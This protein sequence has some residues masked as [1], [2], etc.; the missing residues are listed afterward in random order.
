MALG[1]LFSVKLSLFI[2]KTDLEYLCNRVVALT[3]KLS[4]KS[5]AQSLICCVNPQ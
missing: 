5:I 2:C 4:G 3:E 1:K